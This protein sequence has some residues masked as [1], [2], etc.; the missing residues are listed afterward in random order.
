MLTIY[1]T[2]TSK[3]Q[4][5]LPAAVRTALGLCNGDRIAITVDEAG[6]GSAVLRPIG[7]ITDALYASVEP[8][9]RPEDFDA[10]HEAFENQTAAEVMKELE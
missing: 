5:T 2:L 10:Q 3:G 8:K 6:D 4:I 9:R 7:S 1:A